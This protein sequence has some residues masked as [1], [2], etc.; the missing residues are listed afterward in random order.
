MTAE[1]NDMFPASFAQQRLWFLDQLQPGN[2]AY[3]V[4]SV[5]RLRGAVDVHVLEESLNER[6]L[7]A[8]TGPERQI[9]INRHTRFAPP[10]KC[11]SA[12]VAKLPA[13]RLA[14]RL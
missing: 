8:K 13:M 9:G 14:D 5:Q 10:L 2:A 1:Q 7:P 12:D 6:L 3:N 4:S 11:Q